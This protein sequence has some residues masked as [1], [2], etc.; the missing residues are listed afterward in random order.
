MVCQIPCDTVQVRVQRLLAWP[1]RMSDGT[2]QNAELRRLGMLVM[3][4]RNRH[5]CSAPRTVAGPAMAR[6][7]HNLRATMSPMF[8]GASG[9]RELKPA[10][11]KLR[12]D[13]S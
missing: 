5:S 6:Q 7:T 9:L 10:V 13:R 12:F 8:Q 1:D 3:A 2:T 11:Q 4:R